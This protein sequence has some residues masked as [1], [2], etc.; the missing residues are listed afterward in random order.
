MNAAASTAD[1]T[2]SHGIVVGYDG[3]PGSRLALDWAVQ[4]AKRDDRPL[5]L[6]HCVGLTMTPTF[7]AYDPG[8]QAHAYDE[9]SRGVLA[10]AIEIAA[11]TMDRSQIHPLSVIG[12]AAAELVGVSAQ[13]DLV[14]TG[15]RGH[16]AISAGLLGSTSYAVTAHAH[17]PA[18]VVR[19]DTVVHAGR[20]HPVVVAFDDSK[21][22]QKALETGVQVAAAA[23]APLHVVAVDNVGGLE[24]W[25]ETETMLG[26]EE[27][28]DQMHRR[29]G[30]TLRQ[31][32]DDVARAHPGLDVRTNVLGG[33]AGA[34]IAAYAVDVKAGL[35]VMGSRG[36]G[37]FT[38]M[39]L[40][41]VSHRVVH[42]APCP[43]MVIH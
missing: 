2:T 28:M 38:G 41:S 20:S 33:G 17:C 39:L 23:E 7:R 34:A 27:M 25:P 16:G 42:D 40:G 29:V 9:M 26:R 43:V 6:L 8:V 30:E 11:E 5:T 31:V 3:S 18:V 15:S 12:S 21:N 35:V 19:G 4:T 14:V 1:E 24:A 37:G 32:A 22:A 36:H 10:E 13:A